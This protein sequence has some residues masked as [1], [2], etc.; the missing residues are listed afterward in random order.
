MKWEEGI[1]QITKEYQ[2]LKLAKGRA[3]SKREGV[4]TKKLG[5]KPSRA[6][7]SS[8]GNDPKEREG[9]MLQKRKETTGEDSLR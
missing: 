4:V 3:D 8:D 2:Y 5:G 9:L 7:L 6:C 1:G